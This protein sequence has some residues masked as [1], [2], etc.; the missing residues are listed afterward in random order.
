M[1]K[2]VQLTFDQVSNWMQRIITKVDQQFNERIALGT[3]DKT[4]KYKF[5]KVKKAILKQLDQLLAEEEEEE[6]AV[7]NARDF[8]NEFGSQEFLDKNIRVKPTQDLLREADDAKTQDGGGAS[9]QDVFGNNIDDDEQYNK[10]V[11]F[12]LKNER[13]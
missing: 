2:K 1:N 5:D 10:G 12:E 3:E 6:R 7:I 8:M 9:R 11:A 13:E 4:V